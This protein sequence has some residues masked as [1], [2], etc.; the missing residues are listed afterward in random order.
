MAFEYCISLTSISLP[1][2]V[3]EI[4]RLAFYKCSSLTEIEI[5]SKVV[6][7]GA[8][9]FEQCTGL[10]KIVFYCD[11]LEEDSDDARFS[12]VVADGYYPAG[13]TTWKGVSSSYG[14]GNFIWHEMS[15]KSI[16]A[17]LEK[18]TYPYTGE[19]IC[20]KVTVT[21]EG[22][23][24]KEGTDYTLSYKNNVE[25][26]TGTVQIIGLGDYGSTSITFKIAEVKDINNAR[27]EGE[28]GDNLDFVYTGKE[29]TPNVLVFYPDGDNNKEVMLAKN[30]DYTIAYEKNKD[31]G[32]AKI[33]ITGTG[34]YKGTWEQEFNIV[35]PEVQNIQTESRIKKW[36][37]SN[38]GQN[39]KTRRSR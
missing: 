31:W 14:Q 39:C 25:V 4:G 8:Y 27:F 13:N 19:E 33:I 11:K 10:K 34:E 5:P 29:I 15:G 35:P 9:A 24:L 6:Q 30:R 20:P 23:T 12:G 28:K 32:T 22:K 1:S 36:N 2:T 16:E 17:K 21:C 37:K 26:G 18:D 38:L 7:I 3:T